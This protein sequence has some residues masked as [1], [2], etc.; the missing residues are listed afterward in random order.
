L[1]TYCYTLRKATK[2]VN[3]D[4]K[5]QA[6]P[7]FKFAF[8]NAGS[9]R[10]ESEAVEARC[11]NAAGRAFDAFQKDGYVLALDGEWV[12]LTR[13]ENYLDFY[14]PDY[15]HAVVIGKVKKVGNR[16]HCVAQNTT[17]ELA[18]NSVAKVYS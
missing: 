14:G 6:L 9:S 18:R 4:G 8:A 5:F 13:K 7:Q 17:E 11:L 3:V 16:L 12:V 2:N 1:S 15:T 10:R